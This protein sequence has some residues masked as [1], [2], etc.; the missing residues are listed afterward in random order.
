LDGTGSKVLSFFRIF[1]SLSRSLVFLFKFIFSFLL[2]F[3]IVGKFMD[4]TASTFK[5]FLAE[6]SLKNSFI[7]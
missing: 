3:S 5:I 4:S 6:N 7:N 1:F 2:S